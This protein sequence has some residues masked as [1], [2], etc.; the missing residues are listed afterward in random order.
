MQLCLRE[1]RTR[2][3]LSQAEV[4][5]R[6]GW[7]RASAVAHS[8]CDA[9]SPAAADPAPRFQNLRAGIP[10]FQPSGGSQTL[11]KHAQ[12]QRGQHSCVVS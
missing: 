7:Q 4:A 6:V 3:G 1:I 12:L 11:A 10:R 2:L 5:A 9:T 8:Y